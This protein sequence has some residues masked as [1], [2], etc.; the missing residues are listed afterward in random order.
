MNQDENN[1]AYKLLY[2][3]YMLHEWRDMSLVIT[4]QFRNSYS[5]L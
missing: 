1:E 3:F 5:L 2:I 4:Q